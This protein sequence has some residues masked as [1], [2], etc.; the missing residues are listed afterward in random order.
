MWSLK[1]CAG[2]FSCARSRWVSDHYR[3]LPQPVCPAPANILILYI[4]FWGGL[5][6]CGV[7]NE[8]SLF[9]FNFAI[10]RALCKV[11]T[12][13]SACRIIMHADHICF[14]STFDQFQT[15]PILITT[16]YFVFNHLSFI[17][18][19]PWRLEVKNALF[20]GVQNYSTGFLLQIKWAKKEI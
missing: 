20:S 2:Q 5:F 8:H 16:I 18:N 11:N 15:T 3:P 14:S 12:S 9:T 10:R 19:C 7:L 4:V 17:Y 6:M 1:P 13:Y